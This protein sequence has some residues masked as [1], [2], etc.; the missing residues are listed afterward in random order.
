M[1]KETAT[2][3]AQKQ[4]KNLA[5]NNIKFNSKIAANQA[6]KS[7]KIT[8]KQQQIYLGTSTNLTQKQQ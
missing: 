1:Y 8:H 4:K 7:K 5:R 3:Q 6:Q 2:K